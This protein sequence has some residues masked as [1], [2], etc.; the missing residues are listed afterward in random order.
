MGDKVKWLGKSH[1]SL[2]AA[3][4]WRWPGDDELYVASHGEKWLSGIG[5]FV[6]ILTIM[7]VTHALMDLQDSFLVVA[8]MGASAVL[9]FAIPHGVMSQPW[10]VLGGHLVSALIG[11]S[12]ASLIPSPALASALAVSLSIIAMYYLRCLHPPGGATA[13]SA[14]IGGSAVQTMGFAFVIAP[15]LINVLL[16]LAVGY[17]FNVPFAWRRYPRVK[18]AP[19]VGEKCMIAHSDLVY[20]LTQIDSF[21]DV[22]EEDLLRIYGL[23]LGHRTALPGEGLAGPLGSTV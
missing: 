2:L 17:L 7:L 16:L 13:L 19:Q 9:L 5:G 15:V 8:S 11:V 21:I 14:V 1:G 10:A 18:A 12:M 4:R 3:I 20:A 23:A 6:A 22:S